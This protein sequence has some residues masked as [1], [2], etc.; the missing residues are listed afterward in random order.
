[1]TRRVT[2]LV[3]AVVVLASATE[4]RAQQRHDPHQHDRLAP[5]EP[6]ASHDGR[7]KDDRH[8]NRP[9]EPDT[10]IP[11]I[12]DADRAAAFPDVESHVMRDSAIHTFV[13]LDELEWRGDA[14]SG[15]LNWDAMGWVGGDRNRLWVRSE[16]RG[17]VGRLE[18]AEAHVL[19]GRSVARWWDVV[20]GMRH[21][22]QPGPAQTWA[23]VGLQGLAPYWFEVEATA[24]ASDG[25]QTA[26]RLEAEYELLLT[27]RVVLQPLVEVNV[28]GKRN[29]AR[30]IGAGL[31]DT[32]IGMRIRYE[33]RREFAPYFGVTWNHAH[34]ETRR[35][36][37][38][39]GDAVSGVRFVV[40]VRLWH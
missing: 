9:T 14:S 36:V 24:Y 27:N 23:A 11:P 28:F 17:E 40:G 34:G 18:D 1:M 13:L 26:F 3:L 10:P 33:V 32:D 5:A 29:V 12:T 31:S 22:V 30:G 8:D 4:S 37:E 7:D 15:G 38:A 25:G 21:D 16:G 20:A 39:A 6:S 35:L 19:Y 2:P